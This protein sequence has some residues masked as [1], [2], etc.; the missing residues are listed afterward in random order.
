MEVLFSLVGIALAISL[1]DYYTVKNWQQTTSSTRNNIVFDKRNKEYGAYVIRRDY[2]REMVFILLGIILAISTAYGSYLFFKSAPIA[3]DVKKFFPDDDAKTLVLPGIRIDIPKSNDTE[4]T[5]TKVDMVKSKDFI[6]TDNPTEGK[7]VDLID[8]DKIQGPIDQ[9]GTGK[10]GFTIPTG[11]GSGGG[12]GTGFVEPTKV[13]TPTFDPDITAEFPGGREMMIQY[14]TKNLKY[15]EIARQL[16]I[17]GKCNLQFVI[18]KKGEISDIRIMRSVPG[19]EE[20]DQEATRVI[21]KMP[22]WK[23]AIKDGQKVDSY[24]I[25]PINFSLK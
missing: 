1:Y 13:I 22:N 8:L 6:V 21:R 3:V 14:L 12:T 19:C 9:I 23:P 4:L 24:F 2:D 20:C 25:M 10:T 5:K 17:Q 11:G 7:K 18:N 15:P 16:S